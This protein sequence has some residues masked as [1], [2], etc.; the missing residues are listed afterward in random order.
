MTSSRRT[1]INRGSTTTAEAAGFAACFVTD[2]PFPN[3]SWLDAG[4]H[5]ALDP[6]VALSFAAA[7]TV[8]LRLQ[9]HILVLRR[10]P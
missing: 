6:F 1:S 9:T 8:Q 3:K 2:H 5:H 7:A 10:K 4:G